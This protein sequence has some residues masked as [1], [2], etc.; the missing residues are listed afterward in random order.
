MLQAII[1]VMLFIAAFAFMEGAAYWTHKHVMH[2]WLWSLH[3]SHHRPR[4][5]IFEKNDFFVVFFAA[6]SIL[7]IWLGVNFWAPLLWVGL[8]MTAYGFAYLIFHDSI[9]HRRLPFRYRGNNAYMRRI[10]EA[11]W[12][13]HAT[14]TKEGCVSFGFLYSPPI[15]ELTAAQRASAG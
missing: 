9:V 5:G 8:G 10:M 2:G 3:K 12:I 4:E 14:T 6:P 15:E 13:H 11:H 1:N 7:F